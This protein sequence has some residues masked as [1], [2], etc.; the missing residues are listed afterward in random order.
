MVS[1]ITA[2]SLHTLFELAAHTAPSAT[3]LVVIEVLS[4]IG[5]AGETTLVILDGAV[6]VLVHWLVVAIEMVLI[7]TL[8]GWRGYHGHT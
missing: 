4:S 1:A 6:D 7:D 5:T 8:V 2:G 3:G